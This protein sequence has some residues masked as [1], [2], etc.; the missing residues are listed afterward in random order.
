MD[1]NKTHDM[2][3]EQAVSFRS[4]SVQN[5]S[6]LLA[7]AEKRGCAC[8]PY[9]DWFTYKRWLAQGQQ[10][11]KGQHGVKLPVVIESVTTDGNG[12]EQVKTFPRMTT[13][14]C[15]CQVKPAE[16]KDALNG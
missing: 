3:A 6:T 14:F 9:A 1:K 11:Q 2:T 10:V 12:K 4:F 8:Q 5:A 16:S 7:E 15:R 13:V